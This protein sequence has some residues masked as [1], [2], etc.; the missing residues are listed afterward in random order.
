MYVS[1]TFLLPLL[2]AWVASQR[3]PLNQFSVLIR[4]DCL[5]APSVMCKGSFW[6]PRVNFFCIVTVGRV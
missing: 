5:G 6:S 3:F 2:A 1:S 4:G